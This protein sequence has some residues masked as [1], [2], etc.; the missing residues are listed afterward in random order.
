MQ[1]S[2]QKQSI[3]FQMCPCVITTTLISKRFLKHTV[4]VIVQV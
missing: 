2:L 1:G 4:N 3:I